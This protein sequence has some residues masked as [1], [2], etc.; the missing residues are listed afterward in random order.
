M[1]L[2]GEE[3]LSV[4]PPPPL[5]SVSGPSKKSQCT[6]NASITAFLLEKDNMVDTASSGLRKHLE[7]HQSIQSPASKR[8]Q[9]ALKVVKLCSASEREE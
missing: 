8:K 2:L 3:C 1:K 4:K 9:N 7:S 5:H 6:R